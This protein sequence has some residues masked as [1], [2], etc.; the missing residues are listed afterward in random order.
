MVTLKVP[1]MSCGHCVSTVRKAVQ[2]LDPA[3]TVA[4]DLAAKLVTVESALDAAAI[5]E[6][7]REAG[8]ENAR[9]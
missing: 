6:A 2:G 3:A 8:Y 1:D 5:A 9:V 4:V 7:V